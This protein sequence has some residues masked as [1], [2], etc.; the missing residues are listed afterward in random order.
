[1]SSANAVP[2]LETNGPA[3]ADLPAQTLPL[4]ACS[5]PSGRRAQRRTGVSRKQRRRSSWSPVKD[6]SQPY[7]RSCGTERR[8]ISLDIYR[9]LEH[10]AVSGGDCGGDDSR[11]GLRGDGEGVLERSQPSGSATG[12]VSLSSGGG[13]DRQARRHRHI[14]S[15]AGRTG[16]STSLR[17]KGPACRHGSQPPLD[18]REDIQ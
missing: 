14:A 3:I 10:N 11:S 6:R 2:S 7:H 5:R 8:A 18:E 15:R 1:M 4:R 13:G 12:G 9:R 16:S 17:L